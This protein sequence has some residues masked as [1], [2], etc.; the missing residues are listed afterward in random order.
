MRSLVIALALVATASIVH[1]AEWDTMRPGVTTQE[2]VRA[3]LGQPTKVSSAKVEGYD[4]AEWIYEGG[5]VRRGVNRM[6]VAF[7][8]LTP[9]GYRADLVR[10]IRLEVGR[11]AF[12]K[13]TVLLGWG[14]PQAVGKEKDQEV[15]FYESGLLVY[16]DKAGAVAEM[17]IFTPPQRQGE[18]GGPPKK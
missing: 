8:I 2:A 6:V 7:G 12:P 18:A 16:F 11:G 3:H 1:A 9:Q 4:T 14:P 15:F 13:S 10:M 17:M 5:N